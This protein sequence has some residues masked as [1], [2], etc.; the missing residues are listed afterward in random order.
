[1]HRWLEE[2]AYRIDLSA[3]VF[4][5]GSVLTLAVALATVGVQAFKAAR[6]NPVDALRYE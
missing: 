3:W 1:M 4:V 6:A 5:G 2:F